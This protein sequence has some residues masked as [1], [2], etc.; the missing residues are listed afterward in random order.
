MLLRRILQAMLRVGSKVGGGSEGS[1]TASKD[2]TQILSRADAYGR[3]HD[4]PRAAVVAE[5]LRRVFGGKRRWGGDWQGIAVQLMDSKNPAWLISVR[6]LLMWM[7]VWR[8]VRSTQDI[9]DALLRA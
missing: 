8:L 6:K 7:I 5:G 1:L 2:G 9:L 4:L 3:K